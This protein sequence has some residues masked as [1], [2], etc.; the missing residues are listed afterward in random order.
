MYKT[1]IVIAVSYLLFT[2]GYIFSVGFYHVG[3]L[4]ILAAVFLSLLT[5]YLK[6]SLLEK[7][8]IPSDG[9]SLKFILTLILIIN[10]AVVGARLGDSAQ[11]NWVFFSMANRI[12]VFIALLTAFTFLFKNF[13]QKYNIHRVV[14]LVVLA[15]AIRV[16]SILSA[17]NPTIDV[18]YILKDGPKQILLGKNPYNLNYP[19][20]YGVYIPRIIYVYGPATPFI[21]LPSVAVFNDPRYTLVVADLISLLILLKLSKHLGIPQPYSQLFA[22][23]FFYHPFFPFMTEQAWLE[24]LVTMFTFLATYAFVKKTKS[25]WAGLFLGAILAIKSVYILPLFV[26]LK[27]SKSKG[28]NYI[29]A[30]AV[31]IIFTLPF[32]LANASLFLERTQTYVTNPNAIGTYLAPTNV[33]LN[34]SALLLKYTGIILPTLVVVLIGLFISALVIVFKKGGPAYAVLSL[35]LVF[36]TLFMFGPFVFINYFAFLGNLLILTGILFIAEKQA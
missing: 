23:I 14:F 17:P 20:P 26:F 31:L 30:L 22:L 12:L 11:T 19:S 24:P 27:N 5:F 6:P 33:S 16:F 1:P 3:E 8:Q 13:N 21:F 7:I 4:A 35:F 34:I 2:F 9:S 29:A 25:F 15:L 32:L 18:F 28:I 10:V 36:M